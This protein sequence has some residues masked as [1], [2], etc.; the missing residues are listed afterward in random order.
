MSINRLPR[1][2]RADNQSA[3][4]P[5]KQQILC[6]IKSLEAKDHGRPLGP[7]LIWKQ[8][9]HVYEYPDKKQEEKI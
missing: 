3:Q 2:L 8:E 9:K 4:N 5:E 7:V 1:A 6:E